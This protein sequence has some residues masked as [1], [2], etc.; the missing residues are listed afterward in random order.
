MYMRG[1]KSTSS[2]ANNSSDNNLTHRQ[3]ILRQLQSTRNKLGRSRPQDEFNWNQTL[4]NLTTEQKARIAG[5]VEA[6]MSH[7]RVARIVGSGRTTVSSIVSRGIIG[8]MERYGSPQRARTRG[9]VETAEK[10]G[11]PRLSLVK[12]MPN[13]MRLV[14]EASGGPIKY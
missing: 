13:R 10:S 12:S 7:G 2:S 14:V 3:L 8:A 5:M 1:C 6:G 9:T 11:R 4:P